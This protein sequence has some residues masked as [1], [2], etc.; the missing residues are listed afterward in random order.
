MKDVKSGA[1]GEAE[2]E[3]EGRGLELTSAVC[4]KTPALVPLWGTFSFIHNSKNKAINFSI[5]CA[6]TTGAPGCLHPRPLVPPK[7]G[8]LGLRKSRGAKLTS[9]AS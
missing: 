1:P 4:L 8:R 5:M 3:A 7:R 6:W 2:A 9:L